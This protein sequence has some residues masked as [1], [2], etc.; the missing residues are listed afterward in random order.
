[1]CV[2]PTAL[3]GSWGCQPIKD[4]PSLGTDFETPANWQGYVEEPT[5]KD[6]I[7]RKAHTL[8]LSKAWGTHWKVIKC[9]ERMGIIQKAVIGQA[10][11][12]LDSQV[13]KSLEDFLPKLHCVDLAEAYVM[14]ESASLRALCEMKRY[15][16]RPPNGC[17][18][19]KPS[20]KGG[21]GRENWYWF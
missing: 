5:A 6:F 20:V 19:K 15:D 8:A 18:H 4:V 11:I 1:M 7:K 21:T 17:L 16:L 3:L 14:P 2:T 9:K 10:T 12:N 13:W